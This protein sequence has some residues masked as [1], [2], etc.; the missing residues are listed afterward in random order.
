MIPLFIKKIGLVV[1]AAILSAVGFVTHKTPELNQSINTQSAIET[2]LGATNA[3]ETPV[4]LFQSTLANSIDASATQMTL[5]SA[6]TKD[7]TN[8]AS[9][10]YSFIIDEGTA[11]QEFVKADC[12]STVC[13]NMARGLSVITGTTTITSLA[14]KH[15]RGASVKITDAPI[16]LNLT[17]I[18]SGIGTLPNKISYT[19]VSTTS[20][21]N[22]GDDQVL[23]N[24]GYSDF[25]GST[26]CAN[27]SETT[28][29]CSE[30]ATQIEMAS[31]TTTGAT[32]AG[33][34]LQAKYATSS[35][36]IAGLYVPITQN[37][38]KLSPN[39]IATSSSYNYLVAASTTF[40]GRTEILANSTT[41]NP[42]VVNGKPIAFPT[43]QGAASSTL[44]NDGTGSLTWATPNWELIAS[45]TLTSAVA[46]TTLSGIP[47]RNSLRIIVDTIT[48]ATSQAK[49]LYA[50]FNTDTSGNYSYLNYSVTGA[51]S[52]SANSANVIKL[53][54]AGSGSITSGASQ[55]L[56]I[57]DVINDISK[58]KYG[59]FKVFVDL[60]G[61]ANGG[62][63]TQGTFRW[64][65][66]S[67]Q[68][69]SISIGVSSVAA[70]PEAQT[71]SAGTRI[72]VYGSRD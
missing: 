72:F 58:R 62:D 31:T 28:R 27:A 8:L 44:V 67:T 61:G 59:F 33:L 38:G 34:T 70:T 18:I 64:N 7:G 63:L 3:I 41:T 15:S 54:Q 19:N 4:A 48:P 25:V 68:I 43:T 21:A 56:V 32:G 35:P 45:T 22:G 65:N 17:R 46:T 12:T 47:A 37:D 52:V 20:I 39:F 40:I 11:S 36:K 1:T 30:L 24:K 9:S 66:T 23:V 5:S 55:S 51:A 2:P 13:T 42:L 50:Q 29:G 57:F 71:L 14:K 53:T 60:N 16:L 49:G 6:L 10:T 26:G 69:T